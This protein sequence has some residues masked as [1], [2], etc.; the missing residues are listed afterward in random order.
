M[1]RPQ[2]IYHSD[3]V[4]ETDEVDTQHQGAETVAGDIGSQSEFDTAEPDHMPA[5][6]V[7]GSRRYPT[8]Q[9]QEPD[10][11]GRYICH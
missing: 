3:H 2:Q 10:R 1:K 5:S 11:Y 9:R 6:N 7:T 8:R 4:M